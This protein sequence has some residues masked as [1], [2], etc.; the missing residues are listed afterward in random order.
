MKKAKA[1]EAVKSITKAKL[2]IEVSE[3]TG[4]SEA[5]DDRCFY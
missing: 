5:N 3:I 1:V 4:L 2:I